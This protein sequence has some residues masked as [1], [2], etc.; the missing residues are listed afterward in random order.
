MMCICL[1]YHN[2]QTDRQTHRPT[3]IKINMN[4]HSEGENGPLTFRKL[5][6]TKVMSHQHAPEVPQLFSHCLSQSQ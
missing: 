2:T 6:S 3:N 5:K 1:T 4:S